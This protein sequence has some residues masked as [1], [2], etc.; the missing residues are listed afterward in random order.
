MV[1]KIDYEAVKLQKVKYGVI[2]MT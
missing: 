1:L 2:F